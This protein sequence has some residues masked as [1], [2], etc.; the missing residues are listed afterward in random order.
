MGTPGIWFNEAPVAYISNEGA[1][2]WKREIKE[3]HEIMRGRVCVCV[4]ELIMIKFALPTS[5]I[6]IVNS[7]HRQKNQ[8]RSIKCIDFEGS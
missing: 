5:F 1:P 7:R 3:K 4:V 2:P 8:L 6:R